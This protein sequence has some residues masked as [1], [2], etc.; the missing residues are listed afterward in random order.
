MHVDVLQQYRVKPSLSLDASPKPI[1]NTIIP[2]TKRRKK[3]RRKEKH[4]NIGH[5]L[6]QV[7]LPLKSG[8]TKA[9]RETT[10]NKI[11]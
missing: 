6:R 4:W 7:Q 1:P 5:G 9:T 11:R 3:K 10:F 8:K 2:I